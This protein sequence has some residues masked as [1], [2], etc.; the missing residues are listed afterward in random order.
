METYELENDN[1]DDIDAEPLIEAD[2]KYRKILISD[3]VAREQSKTIDRLKREIVYAR[4]YIASATKREADLVQ[5][6]ENIRE[7][8]NIK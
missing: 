7:A 6:L 1:R 4:E 5:M 8:L 3:T 2:V